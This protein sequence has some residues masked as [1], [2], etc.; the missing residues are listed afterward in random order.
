MATSGPTEFLPGFVASSTLATSQY[1]VVKLASTAGEV[2]VGA[3]NT[4]IVLGSCYNDP[5]AGEAVQ[6]A[7]GPVIKVQAEASQ[8]AGAYVCSSTTGRAK[9]T[10]SANDD[11]FGILLEASSAAGDIVRVLV[12]RFNY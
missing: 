5:A 2:I 7:I 12:A 10:T 8:S 4:D 1:K 9:A 3:A 6:I 11:P